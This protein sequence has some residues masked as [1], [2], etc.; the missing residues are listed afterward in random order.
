MKHRI[1]AFHVGVGCLFWVLLAVVTCVPPTD[2]KEENRPDAVD[3]TQQASERQA[4]FPALPVGA[5]RATPFDVGTIID[6]V[7]FAFRP[8]NGAY[9]AGHSTHAIRVEPGGRVIFT[10]GITGVD[11]DGDWVGPPLIFETISLHRGSANLGGRPSGLEALGNAATLH[12]RAADEWWKN[13][14]DG[15]EQGWTFPTRPDGTGDLIVEISVRGA[16]LEAVTESGLHFIDPETGLGALYSTAV[17]SDGYGVE[18]EIVPTFFGGRITIRV[19]SEILDRSVFPA[20][21]DPLIEPEFG[22]DNPVYPP[23]IDAQTAPA[24]T[25]N[26]EHFLIVWN[27]RRNFA[28]T[29]V[30]VYGTRVNVYGGVVDPAGILITSGANTQIAPAVASDGNDFLVVWQDS[31]FG[32]PD[33]MGRRVQADGTTLDPTALVIYV[34]GSGQ[35]NPSVAFGTT[36]YLVVWDDDRTVYADIYGARM[37]PDGTL[38]DGTPILIG[39][40]AST[41]REPC[42]EF[43]GVRFFVVWEDSRNFGA[44]GDDIYGARVTT[45]GDVLDTTGIIVANETGN[46]NNPDL[47]FG[48]TN[49]MVAW[50]DERNGGV[51]VYAARVNTSGNVLDSTGIAVSVAADVQET[52]AVDHNGVMFLVA[53]TDQRN[54]T[55]D[56]YATRV[57]SSGIVIEPDGFIVCEAEDIQSFPAMAF[58]GARHLLVWQDNRD[59]LSTDYNIAGTVISPDDTVFPPLGVVLSSQR[60]ANQE[61]QA[62]IAFDGENYLVVWRDRRYGADVDIHGGR[63]S[64]DGFPLDLTGISISLS[65]GAQGFPALAYGDGVYLVVWE[66]R[67][68]GGYDIYAARL[69]PDGTLLDVD[70]FVISDAADEQRKPDVAF[71]DGNFLVVWQDQR[72]GAAD[73]Y[74]AQV[75]LDGL[76][77]QPAG[78]PI[79][80]VAD[81]QELPAIVS[82]G[83]QYFV[84]WQDRRDANYDI[85]AT[86]VGGDGTVLDLA[87]LAVCTDSGVQTVPDISFDGQEFLVVWQ[88]L[89]ATSSDVYGA[90]VTPDGVLLDPDGFAISEGLANEEFPVASFTGNFNLV[91]WIDFRSGQPDLYGM[92]LDENG[93]P[94]LPT[95]APID[96]TLGGKLDLAVASSGDGYS[97]V[98]YRRNDEDGV[99]RVRARHVWLL[100]GGQ[101]CEV[102][103][104]CLSGFCIDDVCCNETCGGGDTSDCQACD[105]ASGATADGICTLLEA[106]AVCRPSVADCDAEEYCTGV[107]PLCPTD[108]PA[109]DTL[110]CRSAT[111]DCDLAE[112]CDGVNMDCPTDDVAAD[113]VE[114]RPVVDDCDVVDFCDGINKGCPVDEVSPSTLQCRASLGMCDSAEYCDGVTVACPPNVLAPSTTECRAATDDCDQAEFCTGESTSCPDDEF[115]PDNAVCRPGAGVCDQPEF[116]PGDGPVCPADEML[117][118]GRQCSILHGDCD[119]AEFCDGQ[120]PDCPE[121][122]FLPAAAVCRPPVGDCDVPETCPGDSA[123]CPADQ[124]EPAAKECRAVAGFC[125]LPEH[126]TGFH[127]Q[128]PLDQ[129]VSTSVLCREV[130][131]VCDVSEF[132]SGTAAACPE[133]VFLSTETICREAGYVCDGVETCNGAQADCPPDIPAVDGTTCG[134]DVFCNG[135]DYCQD[136]SCT[137]HHG[138]PCNDRLYCNGPEICDEESDDCFSGEPVICAD[139][140]QWCNGREVCDEIASACGHEMTSG[141]RCPDNGDFCDGPETCDET[142]DQ[143]R[144]AGNPCPSDGLFCT[145]LEAC[146]PDRHQCLTTGNPCD[147]GEVC[148]EGIS[149]CVDP[150]ETDGLDFDPDFGCGCF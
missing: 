59:E 118:V 80:A 34:G 136:G 64:G 72:D 99:S 128:C 147:E 142:Y 42:V 92:W 133:D 150:E 97:M 132:C 53:W 8:E 50:Q 73:I 109:A 38:L 4:G 43:D 36:S 51:D 102:D 103:D 67:R 110:E 108:L 119:A 115:A 114:C 117:P 95:S 21:L 52:P 27:D 93:A 84:A 29:G 13:T 126:C 82:D 130:A 143:C 32:T 28:M 39:A 70:G 5:G 87:G 129:F 134:D 22:V 81:G 144:H 47:V 25:F 61:E 106:T 19:P 131:G 79:A 98:A 48:T 139:D 10:P 3:G 37:T 138:D 17:W 76:V 122:E 101:E 23:I 15:V 66:D 96:A 112:F 88:D 26:G 135:A 94:A 148:V 55:P 1:N 89:R 68:G 137:G 24:I 65:V 149:E 104:E 40:A 75:D 46:Q 124:I 30:D 63:I 9:L 85:Y 145:G 111:E 127:G 33:I 86:R 123:Q 45:D 141:Q 78:I 121:D 71:A 49:Y 107:D 105:E 60:P 11:T 12:R 113:T 18:E 74:G 7:H 35:K 62:A 56:I 90:R 31:R 58:D 146:D 14:A 54:G 57:T 140:G 2:N 69:T 77:L 20:Q 41:Q 44:T 100:V 91:A 120:T 125:D 16:P 6:Q 116:C 83:A